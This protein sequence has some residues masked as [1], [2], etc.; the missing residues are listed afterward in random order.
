MSAFS[1][2]FDLRVECLIKQHTV[3]DYFVE[4]IGSVS[5]EL[6]YFRNV[7]K[8]QVQLVQRW[9]YGMYNCIALS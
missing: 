3:C 9:M 4:V 8:H 7:L 5:H 6:Q 1:Y 2:V